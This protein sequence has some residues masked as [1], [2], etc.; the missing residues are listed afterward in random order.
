MIFESSILSY[1]CNGIKHSLLVG[2]KVVSNFLKDFIYLFDKEHKQGE[3]QVEGEGQ[4]GS[5]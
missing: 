5:S 2:I 4:T 1:E 3:R